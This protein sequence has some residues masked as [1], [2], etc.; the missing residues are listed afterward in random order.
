MRRHTPT[1]QRG[2]KGC[3]GLTRGEGVSGTRKF[4]SRNW[5]DKIVPMVSVVFSHDGHFGFGGGG[6]TPL[7]LRCAAVLILPGGGRGMAQ[8]LGI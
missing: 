7:L 3:G 2:T 8:G 1:G 4:V 6:G 5:P